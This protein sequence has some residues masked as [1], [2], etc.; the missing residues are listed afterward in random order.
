MTINV[1]VLINSLGKTYKEIFD[2]GLIPYKTK[3]AGFSGD[4]VV[5]LDMVKEGVG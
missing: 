2:E 3:P 1:E 5:C 4:E